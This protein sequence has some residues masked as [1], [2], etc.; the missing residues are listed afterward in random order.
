MI[1]VHYLKEEAY[2]HDMNEV[3]RA[4]RED[5][6]LRYRYVNCKGCPEKEVC[7]ERY[8]KRVDAGFSDTSA[9]QKLIRNGI[10]DT[11]MHAAPF[12]KSPGYRAQRQE[13]VYLSPPHLNFRG[14]NF[15]GI[16]DLEVYDEEDERDQI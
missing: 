15:Q 9:Q 3:E 13:S 5:C 14:N 16:I 11:T 8:D 7:W 12:L 2:R 10:K 1:A 6:R 4:V